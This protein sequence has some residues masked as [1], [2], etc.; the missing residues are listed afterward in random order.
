MIIWLSIDHLT[1]SS[2][3]VCIWLLAILS[4]T[5]ITVTSS[6][7]FERRQ[8]CL[9]IV[10]MNQ[11]DVWA[12]PCALSH[13]AIQ[14]CPIRSDNV[15]FTRWLH[16]SKFEYIHRMMNGCTPSAAIF[17]TSLWVVERP[18]MAP[19]WWS[20]NLLEISSSIQPPINVSSILLKVGV[21]E[22]GRKSFSIEVGGCHLGNIESRRYGENGEQW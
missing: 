20:S 22:L 18:F 13:S 17:F 15:N 8:R 4:I 3:D 11:K 16:S 21:N 1:I 7:N 6:M 14:C 2:T 5:S 12:K 9:E 10:D 19:N